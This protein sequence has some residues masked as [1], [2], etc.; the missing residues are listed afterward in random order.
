MTAYEDDRDTHRV[1]QTPARR[2]R[3]PSRAGAAATSL[4]RRHPGHAPLAGRGGSKPAPTPTLALALA[5]TLAFAAPAAARQSG[6]WFPPRPQ[7]APL[8]ADPHEIRLAAGLAWTDLFDPDKTPA[9]R[10]GIRFGDPDDMRR[11][12][13]G[14][15]SLGG[16]LPLWG[17]SIAPGRSLV[18]AIQ[19][20]VFARFRMEVPSRDYTASDWTVALPITWN[21]GRFSVRTRILHR[22]SHLGDEIIAYSDARRIEY[23]HE[24]VDFLIAYHVRPSTRVYG[25][26]TWIF[27]SL[28]ETEPLLRVRHP[29]LHDD[30]ALQLGFDAEWPLRDDDDIT[31][32]AGLDLQSADRTGWRTQLSAA[33]GF[34]AR[35]PGGGLRLLLHFFHGT[36]PLGEFFLTDESY[37]MLEAVVTR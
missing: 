22:S 10:P 1:T 25:G 9:E 17:Y 11:D 8:L 14:V 28:T 13:Q 23:A 35:G 36:S 15:V 5:L 31:A 7:F 24:A 2:R 16:T 37:W 33:A 12:L 30:A 27:R 19:A 20:G 3:A 34:G 32:L 26:S 18:V 4:R 21:D 6:Q 29:G